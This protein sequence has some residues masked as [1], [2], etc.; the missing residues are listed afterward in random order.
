FS[1]VNNTKLIR[2]FYSVNV[3][4]PIHLVPQLLIAKTGGGLWGQSITLTVAHTSNYFFLL[5]HLYIRVVIYAS[6]GSSELAVI[7]ASKGSSELAISSYL[8]EFF[9][10]G[11]SY[12]MFWTFIP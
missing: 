3:I 8:F 6:K 5:Y 11:F 7:Y 1:V 9:C 2:K 4:G 12:I 10:L